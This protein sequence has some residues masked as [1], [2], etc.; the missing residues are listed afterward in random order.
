MTPAAEQSPVAVRWTSDP[1]DRAEDRDP[2]MFDP[3]YVCDLRETARALRKAL[4]RSLGLLA[5]LEHQNRRLT[6]RNRELIAMLMDR[7]SLRDSDTVS[8]RVRLRDRHRTGTGA[9]EKSIA[10]R[11]KAEEQGRHS[12]AT[13]RTQGQRQAQGRVAPW[14]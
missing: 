2:V 4:H 7:P 13:G 10:T 9:A 8:D 3:E 5:E 1:I 11:R 12:A 14:I 6:L